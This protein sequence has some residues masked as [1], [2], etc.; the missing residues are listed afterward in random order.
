LVAAVSSDDRP[1]VD[2]SVWQCLNAMKRAGKV[3]KTPDGVYRITDRGLA[4]LERQ[5]GPAADTDTSPAQSAN[6]SRPPAPR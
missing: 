1:W 3:D 5:A 4:W 2:K 6:G